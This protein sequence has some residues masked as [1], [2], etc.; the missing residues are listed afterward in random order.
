MQVKVADRVVIGTRHGICNDSSEAR[1]FSM[2]PIV[3]VAVQTTAS[4]IALDDH[5]TICHLTYA[6]ETIKSSICRRRRSHLTG[7]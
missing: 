4:D 3:F 5:R 2:S 6:L 1:T 7:Y